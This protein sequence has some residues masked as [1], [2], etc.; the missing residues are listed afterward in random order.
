MLALFQSGAIAG[1]GY[2]WRVGISRKAFLGGMVGQAGRRQAPGQPGAACAALLGGAVV[3][4]VHD[5]GA[6]VDSE[7]AVFAAILGL[8]GAGLRRRGA[9]RGA[10]SL[11]QIS[12]QLPEARSRHTSPRLSRLQGLRSPGHGQGRVDPGGLLRGGL[13]C[14]SSRRW[15]SQSARMSSLRAC[16]IALANAS[17]SPSFARSSCAS[18]QALPGAARPRIISD[19][20]S[21]ALRRGGPRRS[22]PQRGPQDVVDT[23]PRLDGRVH[24]AL[25]VRTIFGHDPSPR[26]GLIGAGA[27]PQPAASSACA[28]DAPSARLGKLATARP[29]GPSP[30]RPTPS[31]RLR[32]TLSPD[33]ITGSAPKQLS[34]RIP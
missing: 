12:R 6:T 29:L 22:S 30:R 20:G 31:S 23:A 5:V 26:R 24:K 17:S 13:L 9:P 15:R 21:V 32:G 8:A 25:I 33:S 2:P 1:L 34:S 11:G 10:L 28:R 7:L 14:S 19:R 18:G 27:S 16:V 4:R 3:F